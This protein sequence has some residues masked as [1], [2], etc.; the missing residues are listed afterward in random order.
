MGFSHRK[1]LVDAG[2]VMTFIVRSCVE[3]SSTWQIFGKIHASQNSWP[4][5][6]FNGVSQGCPD[7]SSKTSSHNRTGNHMKCLT[8]LGVALTLSIGFQANAQDQR[9]NQPRGAQQENSGPGRGGPGQAGP[10]RGGPG[11]AGPGRGGPGQARPGRGGPG[12]G[13]PGQDG[14]GQ[15]GRGGQDAGGP[16]QGGPG[17]G[18]RGQGTRGGATGGRSGMMSFLPVLVALDVNRDGEIS[19]TE[20]ENAAKAL[21]TLDKN[22]DGKLTADELQPAMGGRGGGSR[23]AGNRAGGTRG[24]AER[25]PEDRVA[26][27]GVP[28]RGFQRGGPGGG[29][30]NAASRLMGFDENKDGKISKAELPERMQPLMLR[31]DRDNDGFL[32]KQELE[33]IGGAGGRGPG[34]AGSRGPGGRGDTGGGSPQGERPRRPPVE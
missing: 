32:S 15:G 26:P 12:Q 34:G 21:K 8:G 29:A 25:G 33:S 16:G 30:M 14:P 17:F 3:R 2:W 7:R 23:G 31:I 5:A 27:N 22:K 11:Q 6:V 1:G 20:I 13:G 24:G 10:G 19:A 18:G 9:E 28:E 4:P